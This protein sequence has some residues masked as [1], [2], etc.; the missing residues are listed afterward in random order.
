[1]GFRKHWNENSNGTVSFN[2]TEYIYNYHNFWLAFYLLEITDLIKPKGLEQFH[3]MLVKKQCFL[4]ILDWKKNIEKK[5]FWTGI[6]SL[7]SDLI[8]IS[9]HSEEMK[10]ERH[11]TLSLFLRHP[12]IWSPII[13]TLRL[14]WSF[15][16]VFTQESVF[17]FISFH[18]SFRSIYIF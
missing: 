13:T 9:K 11:P 1:M 17:I 6:S 8:F 16:C 3:L 10:L 18:L 7:L 12:S 5:I 15:C 14:L 4:L 2:M